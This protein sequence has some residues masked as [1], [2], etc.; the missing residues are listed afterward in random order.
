[1]STCG[2]P[3]VDLAG[4]VA[5]IRAHPGLVA[6]RDLADVARIVGGDGDDAALID[7][8]EQWAGVLAAEAIV[9][10]LVRAAPR[11]A[12]IAGVVTVLNDIAATGGRAMAILDTVTGPRATVAAALE[13]LTQ[14]AGLYGVPV[15]GG[16][17]TVGDT[18]GLSTFAVGWSARPLRAAHLRPGDQIVHV[19]CLDGELVTNPD[20]A[21]FFSHLRGSRRERAAHDLD[22]IPSLADVGAAWACRD[23]SMP[24]LAGSL[25]QFLESAGGLGAELDVDAIRIPDGVPLEDWIVAFPSYGFLVAGDVGRIVGEAEARGLSAARVAEVDGTGVVTVR[26]GDERLELWDL[27]A[28][29]LTGLAAAPPS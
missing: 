15:M 16:H 12:G 14:A 9:P 6:K 26:S 1:M 27:R 22:L 21:D 20:G 17:T 19:T 2:L 25:I 5:H 7:I 18:V 10:E 24:G 13:G 4:L 28:D 23:I 29:P 11:V 3:T 8:V